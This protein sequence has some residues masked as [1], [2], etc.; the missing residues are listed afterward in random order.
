VQTPHQIGFITG[1]KT[2]QTFSIRIDFD[3][4]YKKEYT[5]VRE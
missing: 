3:P 5:N 1:L 2:Y 4:K